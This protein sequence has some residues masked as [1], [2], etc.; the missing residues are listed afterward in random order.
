MMSSGRLFEQKPTVG[1]VVHSEKSIAIRLALDLQYI[2]AA[3]GNTQRN[4]QVC[5]AY[6]AA[7][8]E[9]CEV[10]MVR[11]AET[12]V[13]L[14]A[15]ALGF[16]TAVGD[17]HAFAGVAMYATSRIAVILVVIILVNMVLRF[18]GSSTRGAKDRKIR[19][20][21]VGDVGKKKKA[22]AGRAVTHVRRNHE[23]S[24]DGGSTCGRCT[25]R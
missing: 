12:T 16:L 6:S 13:G 20:N 11:T 1:H 5:H 9:S 4:L 14:K 15:I 2:T 10:A 25:L 3:T 18:E 17:P 24:V 7:H 21:L 23:C 22:R 8:A 19:V